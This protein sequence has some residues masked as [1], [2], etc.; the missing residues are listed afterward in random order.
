MT[1][2]YARSVKISKHLPDWLSD[3]YIGAFAQVQSV[4][5][6]HFRLAAGPQFL[7][8]YRLVGV[9]LGAFIEEGMLEAAA[10]TQGK[11]NAAITQGMPG[12]ALPPRATTFGLHF[13]PFVSFGVVS[14][15]LRMGIPLASLSAGQ[16]YG[17]E[18][19]MMG[20]IKIPIGLDGPLYPDNIC[21]I[22]PPSR[23]RRAVALASTR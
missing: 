11:P 20:T 5:F 16:Q 23:G 15:A 17:L 14:L 3:L 10:T 1:Y 21:G 13:A 19:G 18:I 9:E 22:D 7:T 2:N 8:A 4:G 12:A 6:D